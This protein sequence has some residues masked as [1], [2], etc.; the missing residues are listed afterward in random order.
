MIVSHLLLILHKKIQFYIF[1]F[2]AWN[3]AK[4]RKFKGAEYFRKALYI[5][6]SKPSTASCHLDVINVSLATLNN[7]TLYNVYIPYI[8][9]LICIYCTLYHL[10]HLAY[11]IQPSLIHMFLYTYSYSFLYTCVYKVVVL[12]LLG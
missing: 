1:M 6:Y 11:A 12:E 7:A 3:V 5:L 4:G 2:E 10:L 8:T 9:H